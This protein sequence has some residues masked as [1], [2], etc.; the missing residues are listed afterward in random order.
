[1]LPNDVIVFRNNGD[2]QEVFGGRL[3]GGKYQM[4]SPSQA[5]GPQHSEFESTSECRSSVD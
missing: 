4:G 2:E 3:G 5:G 1:M